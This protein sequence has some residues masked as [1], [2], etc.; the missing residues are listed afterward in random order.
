MSLVFVCFFSKQ[1]EFFVVGSRRGK[2]EIFQAQEEF[3]VLV[4]ALKMKRAM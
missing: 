3:D 4:L 2:S 1:R